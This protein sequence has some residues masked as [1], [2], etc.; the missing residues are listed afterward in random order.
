ML[1]ETGSDD[2]FKEA[3]INHLPIWEMSRRLL[4]DGVM[5]HSFSY[6]P[7]WILLD[8][9][10]HMAGEIWGHD[11]PNGAMKAIIE[12]IVRDQGFTFH[13][14]VR[15]DPKEAQSFWLES[16]AVKTREARVYIRTETP[17]SVGHAQETAI[18]AKAMGRTSEVNANILATLFK[19]S[20]EAGLHDRD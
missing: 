1:P 15:K 9:S 5:V 10:W 13:H 12:G 20:E 19:V 6:R 18:I 17:P 2:A 7:G 8:L 11:M 3:L 14:W 4:H 16:A